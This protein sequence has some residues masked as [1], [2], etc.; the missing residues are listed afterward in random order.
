MPLKLADL[1]TK[2]LH[3]WLFCATVL[4]DTTASAALCTSATIQAPGPSESFPELSSNQGIQEI[5]SIAVLTGSE[6]AEEHVDGNLEAS[7]PFKLAPWE[8]RVQTDIEA[9]QHQFP[10]RKQAGHSR[11]H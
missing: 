11:L 6:N 9:I 1:E 7:S 3:E 4:L 8:A 5:P 2:I 10:E